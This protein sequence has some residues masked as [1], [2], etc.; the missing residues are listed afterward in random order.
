MEVEERMLVVA[1]TRWGEIQ[2][3]NID[4]GLALSVNVG[5]IQEFVRG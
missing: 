2:V 3:V 4:A 5:E 1:A